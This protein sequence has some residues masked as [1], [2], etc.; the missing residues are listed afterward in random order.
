MQ[1][2]VTYTAGLDAYIWRDLNGQ[3]HRTDGPATEWA[4]GSKMWCVNGQLHRTDGPAII[5][6]DGSKMW[7]LN[8]QLHRTDGPAIE[9]ADGSN[10]WCVDGIELTEEEIDKL[11]KCNNH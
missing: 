9:R 8:G 11:T 4:D 6:Y 2:H 10:V 3:L 5:L 1:S 7:Y